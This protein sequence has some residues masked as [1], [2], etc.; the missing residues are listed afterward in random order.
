MSE[1]YQVTTLEEL[2]GPAVPGQCR[3]WLLQFH[4]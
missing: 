1:R 3:R 4:L 2:G